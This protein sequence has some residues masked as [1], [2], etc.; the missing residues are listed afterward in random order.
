MSASRDGGPEPN[1]LVRVALLEQKL[2]D[3]TDQVKWLRETVD[4]LTRRQDQRHAVTTDR[5]RSIEWWQS[6]AASTLSDHHHFLHGH[7][8][9][10]TSLERTQ[11]SHQELAVR[12]RYGAALVLVGLTVAGRLAPDT[13]GKALKVLALLP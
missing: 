7:G 11:Q 4:G 13:L 6:Q 12:L 2:Q 9:Q 3:N 10:I 5:L 8:S 1:L